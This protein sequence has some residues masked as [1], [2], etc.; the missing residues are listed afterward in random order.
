MS[1]DFSKISDLKAFKNKVLAISPKVDIVVLNH[2]AIPLG[3]WTA[4]ESLQE[5]NFVDRIYKINVLSFIELTRLFLP[6]LED[7]KGR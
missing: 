5:A 1:Q 3:P 7:S 4:F 2:A 6:H